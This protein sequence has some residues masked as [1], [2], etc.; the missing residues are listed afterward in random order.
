MIIENRVLWLA[1]CFALSRYNHRVVII[2]LKAR[3]FQNGSQ[4]FDVSDSDFV[5]VT[6]RRYSRCLRQLIVNWWPVVSPTS[7]LANILFANILCCS[8]WE[9]KRALRMYISRSLSHETVRYACIY[10]ILLA[11]DQAKA[12]TELT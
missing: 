11:T 2:T 12:G 8:A 4:L 5:L 1:R 3:S 9:M 10:L 7:R 6:I